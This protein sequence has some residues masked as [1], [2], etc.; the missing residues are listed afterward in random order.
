MPSFFSSSKQPMHKA[1][2]IGDY[3]DH[4]LKIIQNESDPKK[5]QQL[6][7]NLKQELIAVGQ[8]IYTPQKTFTDSQF[9][10][11]DLTM[12]K[13]AYFLVG[14]QMPAR[15]DS[16]MFDT[17]ANLSVGRYNK[18][19]PVGAAVNDI[20]NLASNNVSDLVFLK[21]PVEKIANAL[22]NG[23]SNVNTVEK[24]RKIF[25]DPDHDVS[26]EYQMFVYEALIRAIL[27]NDVNNFNESSHQHLVQ[28]IA[29]AWFDCMCSG[30]GYATGHYN[31][32]NQNSSF[33]SQ[34]RDIQNPSNTGPVYPDLRSYTNAFANSFHDG[35]SSYQNSKKWDTA[36]LN[37]AYEDLFS[38]ADM[39]SATKLIKR[40]A[41]WTF[42]K[43]PDVIIQKSKDLGNWIAGKTTKTGVAIGLTGTA[44]VTTGV[45]ATK[46]ENQSVLLDDDNSGQR[47]QNPGSKKA[48]WSSYILPSNTQRT[49]D[50]HQAIQNGKSHQLTHYQTNGEGWS[51][52]GTVANYTFIGAGMGGWVG[53][54]LGALA[55]IGDVAYSSLTHKKERIHN[56][57][58]S[59]A[60][61]P[62][63]FFGSGAKEKAIFHTLLEHIMTKSGDAAQ[64]VDRDNDGFLY[65]ML[66]GRLDPVPQDILNN[67]QM[68]SQ[69]QFNTSTNT[70]KNNNPIKPPPNNTLP[71]DESDYPLN[72]IV[73][74][75]KSQQTKNRQRER[76]TSGLYS[77]SLTE[78]YRSP[79]ND[80][81][82][83]YINFEHNNV[84]YDPYYHANDY[85]PPRSYYVRNTSPSY[86]GFS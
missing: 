72:T 74:I 26:I 2:D 37:T 78:S 40:G 44:A 85:P 75:P 7:Q 18:N 57:K 48:G 68:F 3:L 16:K 1:V 9:D 54:G 66:K 28:T 59:Y 19:S 17:D 53:A 81:F 23:R 12:I 63:I 83:D 11:Q 32:L 31:V 33:I 43:L 62:S 51:N 79:N 21:E 5:K 58:E 41:G 39:L 10:L 69:I 42:D 45:V 6:T 77:S 64:N 47:Y 22:I 84:L 65:T 55:G 60:H 50:F 76:Q 27:N 67:V 30:N 38:Y 86:N 82:D 20:L 46:Y 8:D 14:M 34:L 29:M 70:I 24:L 49:D 52:I 36:E 35:Y 73:D 71:I 56:T 15:S 13:S 4:K 25:Q 61:A 80:N